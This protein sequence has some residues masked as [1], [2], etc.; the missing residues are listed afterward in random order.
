MLLRAAPGIAA[1]P[2]Y[3]FGRADEPF[4]ARM[5]TLDTG[6]RTDDQGRAE[7][8][9]PLPE[10]D[11]PGQPLEARF[12]LRV[13][14]GS[15][16]PV[17]RELVRALRPAA[18]VIGIKPLFDGPVP[19]GQEARFQLI[20]VGPDETPE[21]MQVRWELTR[22]EVQYQ[23]YQ[24]Y[25]QWNW[26]PVT[27]RSRVSSGETT[28]GA[29]PTELALPVT[30]GEYE[31]LVERTGGPYAATSVPFAS[32]WFA[33]A[34]AARTPDTLELSLDRGAYRPARRRRC[35]SCRG[36]RGPRLSPFCPTA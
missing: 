13:A 11:D 6:F 12:T 7:L 21:P 3:R 35:A 26:E 4:Q 23:W 24:Q 29:D 5:A 32:G 28:L 15:G 25:G 10:A 36:S 30:W 14:E 17:E 22:V 34:D 33:T 20:G 19:E 8:P 1:F 16:R 18:P 9:F 2:G 27:T 31:L